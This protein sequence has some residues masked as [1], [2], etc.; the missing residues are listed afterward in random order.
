MRKGRIT[1]NPGHDGEYGTIHLFGDDAAEE[2]SAGQLN[3]F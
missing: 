3:L 1:I 2:R